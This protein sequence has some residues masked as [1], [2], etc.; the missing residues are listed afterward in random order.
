MKK[1]KVAFISITLIGVLSFCTAPIFAQLSYQFSSQRAVY[2]PLT[3]DA[4]LIQY[5][6]DD[7]L[8]DEIAL[9]FSFYFDGIAYKNFKVSS[10]GWLSLGAFSTSNANSNNLAISSTSIAPP[11]IAPY[12]DDLISDSI[13]IQTLGKEPFRQFI[14]EWKNVH[15][16][17]HEQFDLSFQVIFY[18]TKN[19]IDFVYNN[20]SGKINKESGGASIGIRGTS[21]EKDFLS[22]DN[23]QNEFVAN[24][25]KQNQHITSLPA[26][27]QVLHWQPLNIDAAITSANSISAWWKADEKDVQLFNGKV[28]AWKQ[29]INYLKWEQSNAN[30]QP[31]YVA[32][33]N[34][35]K[36][37]N[38]HPYIHFSTAQNNWSVLMNKKLVEKLDNFYAVINGQ[39]L[40]GK[41]FDDNQYFAAVKSVS[42]VFKKNVELKFG[43]ELLSSDKNISEIMMFNR[44]LTA[45]ETNKI[46]TYLALKYGINRTNN[47]DYFSSAGDKIWNNN[48]SKNFSHDI[49]GIGRDDASSFLQ[50]NATSHN[51]QDALSI[52]ASI[53]NNN[54]YLLWANNGGSFYIAGN[55]AEHQN[56]PQEIASKISCNY[57]L[58]ATN[59]N[60]KVNLI[61]D[62]KLINGCTDF[63][64]VRLI[65]DKI[66]DFKNSTVSEIKPTEIDNKLVFENMTLNN[67]AETFISLGLMRIEN[68]SG[69]TIES[70]CVNHE[71]ENVELLNSFNQ[72]SLKF[73]STSSKENN[74]TLDIVNL[75][76]QIMKPELEATLAANSEMIIPI[77]LADLSHGMYIAI[78]SNNTQKR[79]KTI[80]V[81]K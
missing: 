14:V 53:C 19:I 5:K 54:S 12:W 32:A 11:I 73:Y 16:S 44:T 69:T 30:Y 41:V 40:N 49:V 65:V 1:N 22:I 21:G 79:K 67:L 27:N 80:K 61:F 76:G 18:E 43:D 50:T 9:P 10:N 47:L 24:Y 68:N 31:N 46:E 58:V 36:E 81:L 60:Q 55:F 70:V 20:I 75:N 29:C 48:L 64:Q 72:P 77:D 38:L 62:K 74:Y 6:Q 63:S 7:Q 57:K 4:S 71:E 17:H 25:G 59:F 15:C 34:D 56:L 28:A 3:S 39:I 52:T 23:L 51:E 37:N 33:G 35:A 66:G 45:D 8:S 42:N 2:V 13:K 26:N 78:L